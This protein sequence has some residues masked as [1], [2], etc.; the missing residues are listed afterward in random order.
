MIGLSV[1]LIESPSASAAPTSSSPLQR[2]APGSAGGG[3][4]ARSGPAAGGSSGTV[5]TVSK[6]GFTLTTSAGQKVTI[7]ETSSTK[8]KKGTSSASASAVTKGDSVLVLGTTDNTTIKATQVIVQTDLEDRQPPR[9]Q[10]WSLSRRVHRPPRSRSVRFRR[11]TA[12]GRG[13]SSAERQR[14]RPRKLRWPPIRG[15]RR[16]CGEAEQRRV[17]GPP[18]RRQLAPSH[19]CQPGLQ[20]RRR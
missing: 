8:Y 14:I 1:G 20:G 3:S 9:Q 16:P 15:D 10:R 19:L 5:A 17:R 11:A 4:N 2:G 13:R 7:D 18:D 12:R 6:S